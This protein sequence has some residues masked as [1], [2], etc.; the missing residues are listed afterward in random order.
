MDSWDANAWVIRHKSQ[1]RPYSAGR[2]FNPCE[3]RIP[4][5]CR[6]GC[7]LCRVEAGW[8]LTTRRPTDSWVAN[9]WGLNHESQI[10]A[11][12]A[13]CKFN[14]MLKTGFQGN[15]GNDVDWAGSNV[16]GFWQKAS[17]QSPG[18]QMHGFCFANHKSKLIQL[19]ANL[20][21]P[22]KQDSEGILTVMLTV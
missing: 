3:N 18:L 17:Q 4:A 11:D 21:W 15:F 8:I 19:I 5:E 10:H 16:T 20:I 13:G 12:S 22:W 9:A 14:P 7:W 1:I 2:E 6:Q